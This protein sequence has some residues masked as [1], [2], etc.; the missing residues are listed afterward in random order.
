MKAIQNIVYFLKMKIMNTPIS[1]F[2]NAKK[3]IQSTFDVYEID[4]KYLDIVSNPKRVLDVNIPVKMDNGE[5]KI[6]QWYRSQHNDSRGP[7]KWGIRFHPD[8]SL[9]EV[10]ALSVWMSLKVAVVDIPLG[11]GKWGIIVDPKTLS[12]WELERLSRGYVRAI[13][14]NIGPFQDIP[15][16]DVNTNSQIMAWMVD[17][18]SKL[19][20]VFTPG[21]FTGK[22]L[23][24]W[25]S[26]GRDKATSLGGFFVLEK[27][28]SL[29]NDT[30][31]WKKVV[32]QWLGN[33]W[34]NVLE[35]LQKAGAKVVA[36]SDSKWGIYHEGWLDVQ[37][38]IELKN[39]K[40][41][42]TEYIPPV[43][44]VSNKEILELKA[45]ILI[46]SALENQITLENV[47]N[48]KANYILE[49]ANG[50]TTKE[51]DEIL[52]QKWIVVIPDVLANA[53][54]VMVSYFEQVQNN[55]NYYWQLD[56]VNTKLYEKITHAATQVFEIS[57][58]NNT[59]L[60]A[61]A[62]YIALKR[63]LDAMKDR[64]EV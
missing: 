56:E 39:T 4:N 38:I 36:V 9:D 20:W 44:T 14:K 31:L 47:E 42:L 41:S 54:G 22:P 33:V 18:Y 59:S 52:N 12:L 17:E 40:K 55:T 5:I 13:F 16:P 1:A 30:L 57:K 6:F 35:Y 23:S 50:P 62:Y 46:P 48:I 8:V 3:Q 28:L 60:R 37:K 43:Q 29:R 10:K 45:D 61:G 64:G 26:L 19:A 15:A 25:G 21:V 34:L 32:V 58:K 51:A 24:I 7:F 49:L 2:E 27:I 11:W 63:I 53:G